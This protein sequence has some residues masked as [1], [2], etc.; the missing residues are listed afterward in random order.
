ML[1]HQRFRARNIDV[2]GDDQ[3]CVVRCVVRLEEVVHV[4]DRRGGEIRHR[5]DHRMVVRVARR[6]HRSHHSLDPG[7]IR[8]VVDTLAALVLHDFA[9]VVEL[10]LIDRLQQRAHAVRLE[11][12]RQLELIGRHLLEVVGSVRVGSSIDVGAATSARR[13]QQAEMLALLHVLRPLEHHVLEQVSEA[14]AARSAPSSSRRCTR[15][16]Q[17]RPE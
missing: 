14:R 17:R 2:A 9:L 7:A 3:D 12:K 4:S 10:H 16:R 13:F 6:E 1:P 11:P 15:E 8:L 5:S